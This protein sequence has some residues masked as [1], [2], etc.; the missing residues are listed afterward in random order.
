MI[1]QGSEDM[2][3]QFIRRVLV[4]K[5]VARCLFIAA[6]GV[7]TVAYAQSST[8]TALINI[9]F[10]GGTASSE[11]GFAATGKTASD[12]WNLYV[13][14]TSTRAVTNL[15]YSD[16]S[17]SATGISATNTVGLW[18]NGVS[19]PMY[20]DYLYPSGGG[21][22]SIGITNL[23]VG[24]YDIYLYGHASANEGN[25]TYTLSVSGIS[26]GSKTTAQAGWNSI[27]WVEGTQ[28]VVFRGVPITN[29]SQKVSV[30]VSPQA[31]TFAIIAGMQ[32]A[33]VTDTPTLT[34]PT[35]VGQPAGQTVNAGANVTFNVNVNGT[36]PFSYQWKLNGT[37]LNGATD[38]AL[39]LNN[40]QTNNAGSYAVTVTNSAGSV[41]SSNAVLVV[42]SVPPPSITGQPQSITVGV[43]T[44]ATFNVTAS[45]AAPLNYQWRFNGAN[46]S[47]ATKS[48]LVFTNAQSAN[49]GSYSVTVSNLAGSI[50]SSNAILT[51]TGALPVIVSQ[52][53]SQTNA[54][55]SSL[56]FAVSATGSP[57]L[58]YQWRFNG[59]NVAGATKSFLTLSN[60]Q[61]I[62]AGVY[63]ALV[64]NTLG[65]VISSNAILTVT[66]APPVIVTQ[67]QSATVS[68]GNSV[69]LSVTASGSTSLNY[70]WSLNGTSLS[71]ATKSSLVFSNAQPA[72]SGVYAVTISNSGGSVTSS[73]ATLAVTSNPPVIFAQPT[74]QSV[75]AGANVVFN[76]GASGNSPLSYQWS[77][78]GTNL[79]GAT[80]ASLALNNVQPADAGV[81]AVTVINTLG[82]VASSNATLT[83][84][85]P[86]PPAPALTLINVDFD[87]GTTSTKVG[88]AAT[89]QTGSDY[90]N[91][92]SRDDGHGGYLNLG[93]VSHLKFANGTVSQAGV[94]VA[95]APGSW[96][97][98]VADGM[99]QGYLYPFNGGNITVTVT[100]LDAGT[101]EIYLYGHAPSNDGNST[102]T[103]NVG[104]TSYGGQTT[105]QGG[106]NSTVWQEGVQY[107]VFRGVTIT[108]AGQTVTIVISPQASSYAI[109]AG[110][111]IARVGTPTPSAPAIV[112]Q[113]Q[114][115]SVVTGSNVNF[116]VIVSGTS[117]LSYQ[118]SFNG[119]DLVGA[120]GASLTL[121]N[122]QP[123]DAG[124]Y[125]VTVTNT[126][127]S[128]ISSNATLTVN[129][130]VPPTAALT[131]INVDFDSGTVSPKVGPAA[132]GQNGSDYWNLYSRDNGHGGY[133]T[134]GSVSNLKFANGLVSQAGVTVAN[135]P[136]AWG[137][138]VADGMYQGYL[139]PFNG[140]N[141][142][143]TVTNLDAGT[144]DIY[145]YGHAPSNDGNSTYSLNVA[146][147]SY[148]NQ[149]TAQSGWNSAVWQ[150]GVQ[151]VVFRAVTITGA[152]QT[153]TIVVSP[154]ASSYAIIAGM[155]IA[156]VNAPI[157]VAPT[158][159][160]QP[161]D[162][163][164][165]VGANVSF[166]VGVT[167]TSP[168]SFQWQYNGSNILGAT[169]ASLSLNNVQFGNAGSYS[170][171]VNNSVGSAVSSNA[172]LTVLAV[173]H[174]P[175][176]NGQS[177]A[178]NENASLAIGL[179][180]SD[181]D[182]DA[183]T[184]SLVSQPS[185]GSLTGIAPNVTYQPVSNYAGADSF[186]FKVN[187]GHADSDV[188]TVSI[189]V[190]QDG[191][192]PLINVDFDSGVSS[193]KVGFAATGQTANHFWNLYTRDDGHGG[194]LTYGSAGKLKF[195]DGTASGAGLTVA[196]APG[197]W[198]NGVADGMYQGYLYPFNGGNI[199]VTVTNLDAG[200][201][202][203]YVYGHA[204]A[205]D[206]NSS[207]QLDVSGVNYGSQT[208]AQGGWNSALW[209]EGVQYVVF[210]GVTIANAGQ[211]ATLTVLPGVSGYAIISGMQIASVT[212]IIHVPVN[213]APVANNQNISLAQ[214]AT[215]SV[216][217]TGS[218][219]DGDALTYSLTSLP[220]H[221][222]LVGITP[223]LSYQVPSNY[224][225]ADS[226]TFKVNDG[227]VDATATVSITVL[228]NGTTS[229]G[230]LINVDF[231]TGT[232]ST[233]TGFAATGNAS[234]DFW[235]FYSREN[236][237]GGWRNLGT[238]SNLKFANGTVSSVGLTVANAA[239]YWDNGS[240]DP[241]YSG[242][243]YPADGANASVMTTNLA[244]GQYDF[245]IYGMDAQYQLTV[246]ADGYGTKITANPTIVNPV[247]WQENVQYVVFR[248]VQITNVDQV[249]TI[250]I[251][252]GA[253]GY[254][255]ISGLQIVQTSTNT[256]SPE[257]NP[258]DPNSPTAGIVTSPIITLPGNS[259]SFAISGNGSSATLVLDGSLSTDPTNAPLQYSWSQGGVIFAG[260]VRTT[261]AFAMGPH[262][263]YL[264][265][266]NGALTATNSIIVE[267]ITPGGGVE[268]LV[269]AVLGSGLDINIKRPLL[270][271]LRRV[272]LPPIPGS[273]S[274]FDLNELVNFQN[275]VL[276]SVTPI[277]PA[278]G[279]IFIDAAQQII[280]A[281]NNP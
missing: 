130:P 117:P 253:G 246:D 31:S 149:T 271:T 155:Q 233:K 172:V 22:I 74:S 106:W 9:D 263:I 281:V 20:Q 42:N 13:G 225:G 273:P 32:I 163:T 93:S 252:P 96:G 114:N 54:A 180:G 40:V 53:L 190:R 280:D 182:G 97:N 166:S 278:L 113:P 94:T 62:N 64:T 261:N 134:L 202:D 102:Y 275:K 71:G 95:N 150:E 50:L 145:L 214:G 7:Q 60:V 198:G 131:L 39:V 119:T 221:G 14:G 103:L 199:T 209:Q 177:V 256:V 5:W 227:H 257:T 255:V 185:Y 169:G 70:Q 248:G 270:Q 135:A 1:F 206:G 37:N 138:G 104:G 49:A 245:Y 174:T 34:A 205:N 43:G 128:V 219:V 44:S 204:P 46:L 127:G 167:G 223:N 38:S 279:E 33:Q 27:V 168:L 183:L 222:T 25:S 162:K 216:T 189:V 89:G 132:T 175:V 161:V 217:L 45:G 140:G 226:F 83:V 211:M 73:N 181:S 18:G 266:N 79:A 139:Y 75:L 220:A 107:V 110:M 30:I 231:G 24:Q 195:A 269:Q 230:S 200:T 86:V 16:G 268:E 28:Y 91:L 157:P 236:G 251:L 99:Y 265:V 10:G 210:R 78:N 179:T 69:S 115:Q 228:Q 136:G 267:V 98:G 170:L 3:S 121:N 152:G 76:V 100:N 247:N 215:V 264:V 137:N 35:I 213:H 158:I 203:L 68:A 151:Y 84:N 154:Q 242:Y 171:N 243:I 153:A 116:S 8:P 178:L 126:L 274:V 133:L 156:Q 186:T 277:N 124:V 148:G 2:I 59:S 173:N 244:V 141:I 21:N 164:I 6:L 81:Y 125:A 108:S 212:P 11:V 208:T 15:K 144:Y 165:G 259:S 142:T 23:A 159:T 196:N 238:V 77:F 47:G 26:Y 258:I 250:T 237:Q 17:V 129:V 201:Y 51:V 272:S 232:T 147:T 276:T 122:V 146:G 105:A 229:V 88:P 118:W 55:G 224:A 4:S 90:W 197:S 123:A 184:Y 207:Y 58:K 36:S 41:V 249:A 111:Q 52:P 187:D 63:A 61:S 191:T 143:V 234:D 57:I 235:N 240:S 260:D 192:R 85:V 56:S 48:S 67:P 29:V 160:S 176:A 82:S 109:I 112:S 92:Y 87:S 101:Y 65:S 66:S 218:D 241:M 19:D 254:A 239:G 72:N 12:F 194:N 262:L 120:T 188:A 80:G 193:S